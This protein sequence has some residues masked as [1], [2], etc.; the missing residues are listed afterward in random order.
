M[1]ISSNSCPPAATKSTTKIKK[2]RK[3]ELKKKK[4]HIKCAET[5]LSRAEPQPH[6]VTLL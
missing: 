1:Q 6:P 5:L 2:K 4:F 3:R